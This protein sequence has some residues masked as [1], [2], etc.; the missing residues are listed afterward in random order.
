MDDIISE[1]YLTSFNS[2]YVNENVVSEMFD[3]IEKYSIKPEISRVFTLDEISEA[4]KFLEGNKANRKVVV[5]V[6]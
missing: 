3:F 2:T 4:H 5:I 1:P 6:D